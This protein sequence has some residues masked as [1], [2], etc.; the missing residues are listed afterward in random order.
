MQRPLTPDPSRTRRRRSAAPAAVALVAVLAAGCSSP[1]LLGPTDPADGDQAAA[2]G[3]LGTLLQEFLTLLFPDLGSLPVVPAPQAPAPE[4]PAPQAPVPETPPPT[5]AAA[6]QDRV[7]RIVAEET[8]Y[9]EAT[10][11]T[12]LA[13]SGL[14]FDAALAEVGLTPE[15]VAALSDDELRALVRQ[16]LAEQMP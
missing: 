15:D 12:L 6:L 9:P 10:V 2:L 16:I 5:P 3:Q 1:G 7:I 8:G 11:R 4:A 14:S 13:R